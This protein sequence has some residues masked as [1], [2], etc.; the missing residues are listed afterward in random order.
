MY[1]DLNDNITSFNLGYETLG[2]MDLIIQAWAIETTPN[3][4]TYS[5][6]KTLSEDFT[7]FPFQCNYSVL[8]CI[9][10]VISIRLYK[11]RGFSASLLQSYWIYG[12]TCLKAF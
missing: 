5:K 6:S 7:K 1:L 11:S 12:F 4:L 9:G 3:L 2:C 8:I 10:S